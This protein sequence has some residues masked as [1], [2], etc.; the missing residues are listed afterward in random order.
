MMH[1]ALLLPE[2]L[3]SILVHLQRVGSTDAYDVAWPSNGDFEYFSSNADLH[4]TA[5]VSRTWFAIAIPILWQRPPESAL[6]PGAV[7]TAARHAYY[8]AQ[9]REVSIT[10]QSPLWHALA[11]APA[12]SGGAATSSGTA[13]SSIDIATSASDGAVASECLHFPWLRAI[14]FPTYRPHA[15]MVSEVDA[16][17]RRLLNPNR[18]SLSCQLRGDVLDYLEISRMSQAKAPQC[19]HASI[20]WESGHAGDMM[21]VK[22]PS[23]R[24][25]TL[26]LGGNVGLPTQPS[27]DFGPRLLSWLLL[28]PS[29]APLLTSVKLTYAL[30][31]TDLAR[32]TNRPSHY[33]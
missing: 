20:P 24:L 17:L 22:A 25:R 6:S 7:M 5:F 16:P 1:R 26:H 11:A 23:L 28:L 19:G 13:D 33:P 30:S 32:A 9:I 4:A 27:N 21:K 3:G 29:S 15:D 14:H 18:Q 2:I 8:V 12:N 31:A 10:W